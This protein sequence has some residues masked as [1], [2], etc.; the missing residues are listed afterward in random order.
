MT[1]SEQKDT[2]ARTHAHAHVHTHAHTH[3]TKRL[4]EVDL[5]V[6]VANVTQQVEER[7]SVQDFLLGLPRSL[8][9]AT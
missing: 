2:H 3:T 9:C 6:Y 5:D 4:R 1:G 8:K 7:E